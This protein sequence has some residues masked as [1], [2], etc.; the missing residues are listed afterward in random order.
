MASGVLF[1]DYKL[2]RCAVDF[3]SETGYI[4]ALFHC[5]TRDDNPRGII[6]LEDGSVHLVYP[7][8]I[9]FIDNRFKRTY[10]EE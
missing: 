8:R 6:E 5:W 9:R 1:T 4:P 10:M 2:R 7:S 3:G